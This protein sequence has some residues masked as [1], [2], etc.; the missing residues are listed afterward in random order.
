MGGVAG[1]TAGDGMVGKGPG[2]MG[3]EWRGWRG[4]SEPGDYTTVA[5]R[6]GCVKSYTA[7]N[8]LRPSGSISTSKELNPEL[9]KVT[10][11]QV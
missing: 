6:V 7:A 9:V 4:W 2:S 11:A 5:V 3:G 1:E 8:I 10:S